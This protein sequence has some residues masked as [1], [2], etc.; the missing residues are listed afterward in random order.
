MID[1]T[2]LD[3]LLLGELEEGDFQFFGEFGA[4]ECAKNMKIDRRVRHLR[5]LTR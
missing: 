1:K 3:P 4:S 5:K 2:K